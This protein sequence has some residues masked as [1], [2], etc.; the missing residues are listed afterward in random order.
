[1][2]GRFTTAL[3]TM[4]ALHSGAL[5][6]SARG[7][8]G[9][10]VA[11]PWR[12]TRK[13]HVRMMASEG[14]IQSTLMESMQ[15]KIEQAL[16]ADSVSVTDVQGDGRHVEIVVVSSKFEGQNS[17]NRQRMVYKVRDFD[18]IPDDMLF[19]HPYLFHSH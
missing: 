2:L 10:V 14:Q 1:M 7:A 17:V 3:K 9:V 13:A 5:T 12:S 8:P 18:L 16:D 6:R 4:N 19:S 11:S 15:T